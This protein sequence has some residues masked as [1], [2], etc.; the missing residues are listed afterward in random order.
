MDLNDEVEVLAQ[1]EHEDAS[2][3]ED[4]GDVVA[5]EESPAAAAQEV[6]PKA[7]PAEVRTE[8]A[9]PAMIPRARLNE[10]IQQRD[11]AGA[12]AA[13]LEAELEAALRARG[14][15]P[16][17]ENAPAFDFE[18]KEAEAAQAMINGD[19]DA[20]RAIR[21]EIRAADREAL[22]REAEARAWQAL[23]QRQ[24]QEMLVQEK[25]VFTVVAQDAVKVYPFLDA[26]TGD[27]DAIREVI[28][29]RDFLIA[30][31]TR[32]AQ[33][34]ADAV[35]RVAPLHASRLGLSAS[36]AASPAGAADPRKAAAVARN[37]AAANAQPPIPNGGI[38]ERAT[39]GRVNVE[40]MSDEQF[41]S[42]SEDEKKRLRG[43]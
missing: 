37:V 14:N 28:D 3:G 17:Q 4:R 43:D 10:V 19:M 38:G 41:K 6:E 39:G 34:L 2:S 21:A 32:P 20:Y 42:L 24:Q 15:P 9:P 29:Y 26:E 18:G 33:A 11:E 27:P 8:E 35:N 1:D 31:G 7:D 30:K 36:A 23:N 22:G 16:P 5:G 13:Q 40:K 12:R 25:Q